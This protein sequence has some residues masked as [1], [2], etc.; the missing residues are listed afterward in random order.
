[1]PNKAKPNT[2]QNTKPNTLELCYS[3]PKSKDPVC[4]NAIGY[5][6]T[7]PT[8][9][10]GFVMSELARLVFARAGMVRGRMGLSVRTTA[11]RIPCYE[12]PAHPLRVVTH[13]VVFSLDTGA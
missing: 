4:R 5:E 3:L 12:H 6:V 9:K 2:V 1:M 11:R 8:Y 13:R 7:V 10:R